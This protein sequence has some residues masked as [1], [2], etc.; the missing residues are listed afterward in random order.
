[1]IK[2]KILN[3]TL[4][5]HFRHKNPKQASKQKEG[6][7]N[8]EQKFIIKLRQKTNINETR[9]GSLE[10]SVKIKPGKTDKG[11]DTNYQYGNET[12]SLQILK[13]S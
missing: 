5:F 9:V 11:K 12:V 4:N 10:R 2:R 6:N 1:M 3:N 8:K 13:T 7:T